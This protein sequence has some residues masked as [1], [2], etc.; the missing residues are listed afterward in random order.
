ML[1]RIEYSGMILTVIHGFA[2]T[3]TGQQLR[4][5]LMGNHFFFFFF[6]LWLVLDMQPQTLIKTFITIALLL[7][8]PRYFYKCAASWENQHFAYAKTKAQISCAVAVQLIRY[9]D[10]TM[11]L[12][13]KSEISSF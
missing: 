9:T 2:N 10:S 4:F 11:S 8:V 1:F 12:L 3:H 13:S 7:I 6:I 5:A